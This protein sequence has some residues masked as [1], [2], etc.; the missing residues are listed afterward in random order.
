MP[1]RG[2]QAARHP[3]PPVFLMSCG[4]QTTLD[5]L[6]HTRNEAAAAVLIFALD[7]PREEVRQRALSALLQR[8]SPLGQR[9]LLA[10]WHLLN[11]Q[12]KEI[13]RGRPGSLTSAIRDAIVGQDA[14]LCANGC[15]AA[16]YLGEYDLIPALINAAEAAGNPSANR[17][18]QAILE[19]AQQLYDE[20]ATQR[21]DPLRRDPHRL[22]FHIVGSL[23]LAAGRYTQHRCDEIIEAL[24]ILSN[25]ESAVL[26][27]IL[28]SP[29]DPVHSIIIECLMHSPRPGI[30]RLLLSYLDDYHAPRS[31]IHVVS[32]R[33]DEDFI[34]HLLRKVGFE[35]S[36]A[37]KI[38]L[39]RLH[40][41][42]W[43]E[44][45]R[46]P[47][48]ELD[49]AAQHAVVQLLMC[50]NVNR[51]EKF[52]VLKHL[53]RQGKP[54]GRR[55]AASALAEFQGADANRLVLDAIKDDDAH[56]QAFALAQLR[57]RG[58]PGAMATLIGMLDSPHQVVQR[59]TQRCL[60]EFNFDRYV[61]AFD[62]LSEDVR[63]STG[64]LVKRVDDQ[65]P[66]RLREELSSII[67]SRRLRALSMA[68]AMGAVSEMEDAIIER[69]LEDADH[70]VRAEAAA[71]LADHL[72]PAVRAALREALLD[73]SVSVQHMAERSLETAKHRGPLPP[74]DVGALSLPQPQTSYREGSQP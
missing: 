38:N 21:E 71:S 64:Q 41:V 59:T 31:A 57:R 15:D 65:V 42:D 54:G 30:M 53:L 34:G 62:S 3:Q 73:R 32:H 4:L 11:K 13:I 60:R 39:R 66:R 29:L 63:R 35:P 28:Q 16:L 56:V 52:T 58:L 10:R 44:Q 18:A 46:S 8:R 23:E 7:A 9:E 6:T 22:R 14:A 33:D 72:T 40:K 25:R 67:R 61:S 5:T 43:L 74:I 1:H 27:K 26:K 50:T 69:L 19:L 47:L 48:V 2:A 70:I 45:G 49:D 68:V 51:H 24:L 55:A 12:W 36:A 37:M 20:L 17:A